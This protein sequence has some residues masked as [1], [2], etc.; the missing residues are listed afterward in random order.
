MPFPQFHGHSINYLRK[1]SIFHL[2]L[3]S[4][5]S[6]ST[7]P[8]RV[9]PRQNVLEFNAYSLSC[10]SSAR[11]RVC[12]HCCHIRT[13]QRW[14]PS[15]LFASPP[16]GAIPAAPLHILYSLDCSCSIYKWYKAIVNWS[17]AFVGTFVLQGGGI[18]GPK[19]HSL[20]SQQHWRSCVLSIFQIKRCKIDLWL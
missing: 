6:P 9:Q 15:C 8:A 14:R 4:S 19:V 13:W 20:P 16:A 3:S 7:P 11:V 2:E 17:A 1:C 18:D 10:V 5:D 12:W